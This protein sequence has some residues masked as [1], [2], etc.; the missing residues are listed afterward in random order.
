MA[1][2]LKMIETQEMIIE[3]LEKMKDVLS[4][5]DVEMCN[6]KFYLTIRGMT[7]DEVPF[8]F[9]YDGEIGSED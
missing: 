9:E 1:I 6:A 8:E 5:Y 2:T 4:D 3:A 7:A